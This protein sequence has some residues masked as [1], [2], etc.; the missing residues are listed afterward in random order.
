MSAPPLL[1]RP[2]VFLAVVGGLVL[3]AAVVGCLVGGLFFATRPPGPEVV[4][5]VPPT[6]GI[7][8]LAMTQA[9]AE[10]YAAA[11]VGAGVNAAP[12]PPMTAYHA[13]ELRASWIKG[14]T[15]WTAEAQVKAAERS[16]K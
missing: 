1:R 13:G 14:W 16:A 6:P 2:P 8:Q 15:R 11:A 10:G 9:E 4:D 7:T 5:R 3:S 12:Y